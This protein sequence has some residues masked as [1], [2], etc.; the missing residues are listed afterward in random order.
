MPKEPAM[1][2]PGSG[3]SALS[4]SVAPAPSAADSLIR[5]IDSGPGTLPLGKPMSQEKFDLDLIVIGAGPGGY[6]AAIRAAQLGA[7]V[8][9]VEKEYL[10]G[11][12]LNWGCIPSK[13]MIATVERYQDVLHANDLGIKVSGKVEVDFE[14][15]GAR[16]DKIVTTLRGGVGMLFK[17]NKIEHIEGFARFVDANTIEIEK[18]G[19]K[20]KKTAKNF[21][22]AM[23][24][25]VIYLQ[26]PGLEGG[27]EDGVWTSDDAVTAP[28][29]PERMLIL[30]AG[31]V[32]VE[33]GYVFN[34][35]GTKV[36][37]VE[38]MPRVI[39]MFD[40]DLGNELGKLLTRQGMDVLTG[41]SLESAK[42][43]KKGWLC[44]V[45][46]GGETKEVEVDVVLL[47]VGRKA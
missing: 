32:G 41:A 20:A 18:D 34:G 23:G 14:Q 36:T 8:A 12:C 17:K 47:G 6:V 2:Q 1:P 26:V 40:E 35:L 21:I 4:A 10:G 39:P 30:G 37:L 38:M 24:S 7:K 9:V 45:K 5:S 28:F 31:A 13:A 22:L 46:Q 44:T 25:A 19:K 43:T 29:V 3:A 27:R 11:T 33:F 42:K 15:F 16:R